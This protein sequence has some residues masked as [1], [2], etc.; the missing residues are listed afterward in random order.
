MLQPAIIVAA[1]L[2]VVVVVVVVVVGFPLIH[3]HLT[4]SHTSPPVGPEKNTFEPRNHLS[5][6][7]LRSLKMFGYH[8]RGKCF[9]VLP[10]NLLCLYMCVC[11]GVWMCGCGCVRESIC[12]TFISHFETCE[13]LSAVCEPTANNL[14]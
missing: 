7:G 5:S 1:V 3:R 10:M 8:L 13:I 6:F 12:I 14:S 4:S 2:V 9:H 11:V